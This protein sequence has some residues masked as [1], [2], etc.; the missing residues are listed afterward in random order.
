MGGGGCD[1]RVTEGLSTLVREAG[2]ILRQDSGSPF[3]V[4][5]ADVP[6]MLVGDTHMY[7]TRAPSSPEYSPCADFFVGPPPRGI[8]AANTA[9]EWD[10]RKWAMVVLPLPTGRTA[11]L[12]LL[13]HEAFHVAQGTRFPLAHGFETP[14]GSAVLDEPSA[15]LWLQLEWRALANALVAS[16]SQQ[17]EAIADALAFRGVRLRLAGITERERQRSLEIREGLAEYVAWKLVSGSH[18]D[19]ALDLRETAPGTA[20]FVRAFAYFTGPAYA[21]LLDLHSST[22]RGQVAASDDL[23]LLLEA[24]LPRPMQHL[25][26]R[27]E[28]AAPRYGSVE[29]RRSEKRRWLSR[30]QRVAKAI[31]VFSRR[32]LRLRPTVLHVAFDPRSLLPLGELGTVFDHV[33]WRASDGGV[34]EAPGGA[35]IVPDWSELRVPLGDIVV[36]SGPLREPLRLTQPGWTLSLP[37]GWVAE[38][39]GGDVILKPK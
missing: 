5:L 2:Q 32:T 14:E 29:I 15:R 27:A 26:G 35:L 25:A 10:G 33:V 21:A 31:S 24:T 9:V 38:R 37:P 17:E 12:R 3:G 7:L 13:V 1:P 28:A 20:S 8:P 18:A 39:K 6:W 22:W 34:L 16:G 30:R 19:L 36:P 4:P 11:A 23:G